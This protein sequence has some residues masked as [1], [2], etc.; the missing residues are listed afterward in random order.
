[1]TCP[2]AWPP[3]RPHIRLRSLEPLP[4]GRRLS[5][6]GLTTLAAKRSSEERPDRKGSIK[7]H[8]GAPDIIAPPRYFR[9][10]SF[11]RRR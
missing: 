5:R 9:V 10:A 4:N 11:A 1:M 7:A 2:P 6:T 3:P 8:G